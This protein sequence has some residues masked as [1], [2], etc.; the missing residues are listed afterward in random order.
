M[1]PFVVMRTK[2]TSFPNDLNFYRKAMASAYAD[3][4]LKANYLAD[5]FVGYFLISCRVSIRAL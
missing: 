2:W 1:T 4:A 5:H 3:L